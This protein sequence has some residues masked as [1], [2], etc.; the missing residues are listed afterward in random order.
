[1]RRRKRSNSAAGKGN[2]VAMGEQFDPRKLLAEALGTFT[3]VFVG[4]GAI[5]LGAGNIKWDNP[6]AVALAHGL[7]IAVMM[8][9]LGH[10]SGSHF[11]PA[12]TAGFWVTRRIGSAL[13]VGYVIAQL[14][15]AVLAALLIVLLFPEGMREASALGTPSV[16]PGIEFLQGVGIEAVLTFVLV[17]VFF[18]TVVD[19]RGP[20][21]GGLAVG[22]TVT[23]A[24]LAADQLTGA[25]LN[26]ARVFGPALLSGEWQDHLT[27]WIGPIVGGVLAAMLYHYVFAADADIEDGATGAQLN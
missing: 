14:I 21:L 12:I 7:A 13:A 18:G 27:W 25:A 23:V 22:L 6:L 4:V 1:M 26:P 24:M 2:V 10:I 15:G 3:F 5:V 20:K 19:S 17:I 11:N 16:A 9:A 8:S